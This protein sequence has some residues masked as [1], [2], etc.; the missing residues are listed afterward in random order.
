MKKAI[1]LLLL[2]SNVY[3]TMSFGQSTNQGLTFVDKSFSKIVFKDT[4]IE[5][6]ADGFEFTE[7]PVWHKDGYLLFSDIPANKIYKYEPGNGVSLYLENSGYIGSEDEVKGA[8][9]NGLTFDIAGNLLICQHGAR[10]VLKADRAG[11]YTP[12]ARQYGGKRLNSPNDLVVK[13]DGTIFFTDPPWGLSKGLEDP[14]KELSFQGVYKLTSG[15]LELI[16]DQLTMPNG[17]ALSADEKYLY[18][19]TTENGKAQYFRYELD[20]Y[21]DLIDKEL[22][23]D[24]GNLNGEGG[25]DGMKVDQK[26]NCYFTGPGGIIVVNPKGKHIGTITPPEIPANL[27]W[28]GKDGKTLFMT[29]RTGLYSIELKIEGV[30][31]IGK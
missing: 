13:S 16:D 22:F 29:C 23:F 12:I 8:G 27:G 3:A 25:A 24:A 21:G 26:G 9:S 11:N 17:I 30:R 31:P 18:V 4:R 15:S 2:F 19:A 10:Q 28:G 20:E 14:L 6:L 7:G 5:K 1:L